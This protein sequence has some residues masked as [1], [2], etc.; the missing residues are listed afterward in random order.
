MIEPYL[1][2]TAS[3][4]DFIS[5]NRGVGLAVVS[6]PSPD[7]WHE[8]RSFSA[9]EMITGLSYDG[10]WH[11]GSLYINNTFGDL[12][13]QVD[14]ADGTMLGSFSFPASSSGV[15]GGI[16]FVGDNLYWSDFVS[17]DIYIL[18]PNDGSVLG[19]FTSGIS[20]IEGMTWDGRGLYISDG[21]GETI[22]VF[23]PEP[24]TLLLLG[25][26]GMALLRKRRTL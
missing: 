14:P 18:D 22:H 11:D 12:I 2:R 16:T 6:T 26:G 9:P 23:V 24:A 20:G 5:S 8:V 13:Y 17:G 10:D 15:G 25:L 4:D 3:E 1:L 7:K 21:R 19:S